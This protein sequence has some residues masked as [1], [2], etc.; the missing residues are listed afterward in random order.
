MSQISELKKCFEVFSQI[1]KTSSRNEKL[2]LLEQNESELLK[3]ILYYTF[4]K[5]LVYNI[6]ERMIGHYEQKPVAL[7]SGRALFKVGSDAGELFE[8][9]D[10]LSS[11]ELT[12]NNAMTA[13]RAFIN[14]D[15]EF[16]FEWS[17]RIF[18]KDLKMGMSSK[19]INNVFK[20][21]IPIFSVMKAELWNGESLNRPFWL[22][23]KMN[24][25]RMIAFNY[26]EG[27]VLKSSNGVQIPGFDFI[28]E[29]I[30]QFLPIGYA[31]D[32]ELADK[33]DKFSKIQELAFSEQSI[34]KTSAKYF[35]WDT[36]PIVE[37]ENE[38]TLHNYFRRY[39]FLRSC[40][41][42]HHCPPNLEILENVFEYYA[43]EDDVGVDPDVEITKCFDSALEN[44]WEGLMIKFNIPYNW[45]RSRDMLK[46]KKMKEIDLV[47]TGVFEGKGNLQ[48][49]LGGVYVDYKGYQV[50]V[51]SGFKTYSKDPVTG[52][53]ID[54]DRV[55]FWE[56]PNLIIDKV[57]IVKYSE[58]MKDKH[59]NLSLQ[60]P[61]F[62][63]IHPE[64]ND[65]LF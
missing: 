7:R 51:G 60:F 31:F 21:L 64:K 41:P 45:D 55:K 49:K 59:G 10:K 35:M 18:L 14:Q 30:A 23:R 50:G 11:N 37:W 44:K 53:R 25:Y 40:L 5:A 46:I 57:I 56:N 52:E 26:P 38:Q 29:Q 61:V 9:L 4:N 39:G 63:G 8:L 6:G 1:E 33:N 3:Q 16:F 12:G 65:S 32:G 22:Q 48:G 20:D 43:D 13:V 54:G 47:V 27:V 58:E 34:D 42:Q 62:M 2:S 17:R 24:G 36:M 19:T 15:D 28:K